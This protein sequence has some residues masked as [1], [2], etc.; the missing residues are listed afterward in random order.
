M[1]F[2]RG[3]P[4]GAIQLMLTGSWI[5]VQPA[6]P[7]EASQSQLQLVINLKTHATP[8]ILSASRLIGSEHGYRAGLAVL[9][10]PD[11]L[12]R[13]IVLEIAAK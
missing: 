12:C 13:L 10:G 5:V 11:W 3:L 6:T 2:R 8:R 7:N 4:S 9:V 1:G